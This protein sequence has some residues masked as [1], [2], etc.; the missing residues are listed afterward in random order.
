ML[1]EDQVRFGVR[2]F[3]LNMDIKQLH[4]RLNK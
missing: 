4:H 1:S 2:N 3:F